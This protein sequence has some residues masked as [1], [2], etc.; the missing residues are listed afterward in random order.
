MDRSVPSPIASDTLVACVVFV[1]T[2]VA[3]YVRLYYGVGFEDEAFYAAIPYRFVLGD[4]PFLD[5]LNAQQFSAVLTFPLVKSWV[6]LQGGTAG[7]IL[8]LRHVYLIFALF[9]GYNVFLAVRKTVGDA[10]AILIALMPVLFVPFNIPTLSYNTMGMGLLTIGVCASLRAVESTRPRRLFVVA[11]IAHGLACVAYPSL[12]VI[13]LV[14]LVLIICFAP[15]PRRQFVYAYASPVAIIG[16]LCAAFTLAV[17]LE[18]VVEAFDYTVSGPPKYIEQF[19]GA[20]RQLRSK[21]IVLAWLMALLVSARFA[22][23]LFVLFATTLPAVLFAS[24][25][26][27]EAH[28]DTLFFVIYLGAM[29]PVFLAAVGDWT[30]IRN[31]ATWVMVPSIVGALAF[32]ATSATGFWNSSLGWFVASVFTVTFAAVVARRAFTPAIGRWAILL[33]IVAVN[34]VLVYALFHGVYRDAPIG[35][36]TERVERGPYA[37]LYTTR[38]RHTVLEEMQGEIVKRETPDGRLLV[39]DG[40]S[41]GYLMS[42]MRPATNSIWLINWPSHRSIYIKGFERNANPNN[43]VVRVDSKCQPASATEPLHELVLQK[44]VLVVDKRCYQIYTGDPD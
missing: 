20:G 11:G 33:P 22:R 35:R 43:V 30:S 29:L 23:P 42:A 32:S 34:G 18:H 6:W 9:V 39:Y 4:I 27:H 31:V 17:G 41:A 8:F 3:V 12:A 15:S 24:L 38:G 14:Q 2:A 28:T 19:E 44:H 1:A 10:G 25:A 37:G 7:L 5:E 21:G 40:F 16:G 13:P 26:R 36:L